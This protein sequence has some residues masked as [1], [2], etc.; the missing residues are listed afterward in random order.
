MANI[1][2]LYANQNITL[3]TKGAVDAFNQPTYTTS[4]IKGRMQHKHTMARNTQGQEVLSEA[5][6]FTK[7]VVIEGDLIMDGLTYF[8]VITV[9]NTVGLDG[10]VMWYEVYL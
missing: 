4:T 6:V 7:S 10:A 1:L 9:E 8:P 2:D 3:K 5:Q